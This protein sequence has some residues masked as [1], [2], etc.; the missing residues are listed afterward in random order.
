MKILP[1]PITDILIGLFFVLLWSSAATATKIG[2]V[3]AQ[4]LVIS[5]IRFAIASGL[6]IVISHI[7]LKQKFPTGKKIWSQLVIYGFLNVGLYLGLYVIALQEVSASLAALFI[8]INPVLITLLT[9]IIFKK[10]IPKIV[11][12]SFTLCISGMLLASVP[13]LQNSYATPRGLIILMISNISYSL[14][15]IYFVKQNWNGLHPLTINGWQT[16]FGGIFLLPITYYFFQPTLN[17]FNSSV[18][19]S[20]TWLAVPTSIIAV[21]LWLYLLQDNPTKASTWLFLC[22]ISGIIIASYIMHE[23]VTIHTIVGS[24]LVLAGLF[25]VQRMKKQV[26]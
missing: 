22:P 9:S 19:F 24:I 25:L 10:P 11:I 4:P 12:L 23:P 5:I 2:L 7:F 18:I 3:Y 26:T 17:I 1:K 21:L 15:A 16:L 8:A 14:A 6:M 20:I 13:L